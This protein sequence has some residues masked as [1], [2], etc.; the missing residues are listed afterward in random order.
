MKD[1]IDNVIRADENLEVRP[2]PVR[3]RNAAIVVLT[4]LF[5]CLQRD[6]G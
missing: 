5:N 2:F 6:T 3:N 1:L 4:G